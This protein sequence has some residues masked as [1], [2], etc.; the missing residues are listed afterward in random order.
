[1]R[2]W[3]YPRDVPV[4]HFPSTHATWIDAQ[5]TIAERSRAAGDP[6]GETNA[7]A[8]LRRHLMERYHGAL[9]AYV[10]GSSMRAVGD[11]DELVAG[12]FAERVGDPDFLRG[13]RA[14]GKPLRRWM[15][16]GIS[17]WAR[18]VARDRGREL[19]RS[20]GAAG[21]EPID[22]RDAVRAFD[23][24]WALSMVNTA[25]ARVH[26]DL[27]AEGRLDEHAIFRRHVV[28]GERYESIAAEL[29][30]SRQDCANAVR[31]VGARVRD[32]LREALVDDGVPPAD[33]E[34]A[35]LEVMRIV[36]SD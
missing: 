13:W 35:V 4:D 32:A 16:N 11:A 21:P 25:H 20:G 5:L 1:M 29:G 2:G 7:V 27:D 6:A 18:G 15:M 14:S 19:G 36:R 26:A 12:F 17:F 28:H 33:V 9:R 31:R 24:E 10:R 34:E 22:E 23:A 3:R 8:A 30:V